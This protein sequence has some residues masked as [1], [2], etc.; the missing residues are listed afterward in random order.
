LFIF[1]GLYLV[2]A[3]LVFGFVTCVNMIS[4]NS[5]AALIFSYIFALLPFIAEVFIRYICDLKLYGFV[6][7]FSEPFVKFLYYSPEELYKNPV[8]IVKYLIYSIIFYGGAFGIYKIRKLENSTEIIAFSKLRP[9]FVYGVAICAGCVG[10]AYFNA[11][12]RTENLLL[13]I[14]FGV[15]GVI[16][17]EMIVKKSLRVKKVYKPIILYCILVCVIQFAFQADIFGFEKRIPDIDK[18]ATVKFDA[19]VNQG[20]MF[21]YTNDGERVFL[22]EDNT[23]FEAVE[24]MQN[25]IDL[26]KYLVENRSEKSELTPQSRN[27]ELVYSMKN[28]SK[29]RR[30]YNINY[31]ENEDLLRT[32]IE[33]ENCRKEYFPVLKDLKRDVVMV[34]LGDIRIGERDIDYT[35]AEIIARI[36]EALKTDLKKTPYREYVERRSSLTYIK[37]ENKIYCKYEDGTDVPYDKMPEITETYY[38]RD[39]YDNT[40][41]VLE[42]IGF[43]KK[44][45]VVD[46]IVK[47][48]INYHNKMS[49]INISHQETSAV[50]DVD[51]KMLYDKEIENREEIELI[52]NYIINSSG[53]HF[54]MEDNADVTF[55]LKNNHT[56]SYSF[57]NND[58]SAPECI[59]R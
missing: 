42:E 14:P 48:G 55:I 38:I 27:I 3:V 16:A 23:D 49:D 33:S 1:A 4:G 7:D 2:Y 32:I 29:I 12:W 40:K 59:R 17:A 15:I 54:G 10:Y 44:L 43:F 36:V 52:Y 9:V 25:I 22:N 46:D 45:P 50:Y 53:N 13:L 26:H 34:S 41:A 37:L 19:K 20:R 5:I 47:I 57:D 39:S 56:F 24:D 51:S 28:G 21:Y 35:D 11:I 6:N 31:K 8:N 58:E 30:E 18:V